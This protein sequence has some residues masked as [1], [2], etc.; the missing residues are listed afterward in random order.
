MGV[1][2]SRRWIARR[3]MRSLIAPDSTENEGVPGAGGELPRGTVW[4]A[5]GAFFPSGCVSPQAF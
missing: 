5:K 4:W 3:S 1:Y 2:Y